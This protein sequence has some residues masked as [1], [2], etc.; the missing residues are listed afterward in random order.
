MVVAA[1]TG[2]D[3]GKGRTR[4]TLHATVGST[5]LALG[6]P[7]LSEELVPCWNFV[8]RTRP[9]AANAAAQWNVGDPRFGAVASPLERIAAPPEPW[10]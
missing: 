5:A 8:A 3:L 7:P 2:V 6:G 1:T 4:V 9:E 10:S